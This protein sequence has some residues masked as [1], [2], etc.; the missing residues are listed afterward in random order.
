M[1]VPKQIQVSIGGTL[2][3]DYLPQ[4]GGRF[5]TLA[6]KDMLTSDSP[7]KGS[8]NWLSDMK[9]NKDVEPEQ[10]QAGNTIASTIDTNIDNILG[11]GGVGGENF[12]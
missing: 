12:R 4:K 1:E 2:I 7:E 10:I 6:H 8:T 9:T 5:Y 11:P 3:T